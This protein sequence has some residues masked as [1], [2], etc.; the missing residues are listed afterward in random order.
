MKYLYSFNESQ[1]YLTKLVNNYGNSERAREEYEYYKSIL[2][3]CDKGGE[4]VYRVL[5]LNKKEDINKKDIGKH[6]MFDREALS[7]VLSNVSDV[8][9]G[10]KPFILTA[11]TV[12]NSVDYD[13]SWSNFSQLPEECEINFNV[14]PKLISIKKINI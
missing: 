13:T 14:Q 3:E 1:D 2:E 4:L 6:W 11:K 5:F 12:P 10:K 8:E 9:E 7:L